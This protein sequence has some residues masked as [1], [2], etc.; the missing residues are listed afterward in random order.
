MSDLIKHA[1]EETWDDGE[2]RRLQ[3]LQVVHQ[4]SDV[5]L[6]VSDSS[7]VDEDDALMKTQLLIPPCTS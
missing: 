7:P 4:E 6:E 2:D 1:V 3:R 5:S